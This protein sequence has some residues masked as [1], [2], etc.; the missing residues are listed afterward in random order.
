MKNEYNAQLILDQ[1]PYTVA[2]WVYAEQA[3]D[4][5]NIKGLDNGMLVF[6]KKERPVVL[7]SNEWNLNWILERNPKINFTMVP[8]EARAI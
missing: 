3:D 5:L 2:R 7:V 4:I 8:T 1:L 6:D